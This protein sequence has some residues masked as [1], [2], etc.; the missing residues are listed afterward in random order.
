MQNHWCVSLRKVQ[1]YNILEFVGHPFIA[2]LSFCLVA[3]YGL[4]IR[5]G[6]SK[7]KDGDLFCCNPTCGDHLLVTGA[8]GVFK[9]V[10]VDSVLV[11]IG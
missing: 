5:R 3:I 6:M 7:E 1:S 2:N 9:Q 8:G 10:L 11:R 4:E